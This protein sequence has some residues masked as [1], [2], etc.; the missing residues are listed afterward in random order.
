MIMVISCALGFGAA[1]GCTWVNT[2]WLFVLCRFFAALFVFGSYLT[3]F[4]YC[5]LLKSLIDNYFA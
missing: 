4:V 1:I 3:S 2:Y 5:K